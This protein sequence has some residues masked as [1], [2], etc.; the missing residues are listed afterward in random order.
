MIWFAETERL[1]LSETVHGL[2]EQQK[3]KRTALLTPSFCESKRSISFPIFPTKAFL[4]QEGT[5]SDDV[6]KRD[7]SHVCRSRKA[8][9]R[10][11]PE[12]RLLPRKSHAL[13]FELL[14]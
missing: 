11:Q 1:D 8:F 7:S 2:K 14:I 3:V 9:E 13:V 4:K 10:V 12:E 6:A 5:N